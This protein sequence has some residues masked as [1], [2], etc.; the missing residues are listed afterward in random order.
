MTKKPRKNAGNELTQAEIA[1]LLGISTRRIR[2][3]TKQGILSP[4][5]VGRTVRYPWPKSREDYDAYRDRL[6]AERYSKSAFQ[7]ER[8]LLVR[9]QRK[10]AELKYNK[11]LGSQIDVD[12]ADKELERILGLLRGKMLN[13]RGR[14]GPLMVGRMTVHAAVETLDLQM[15]E[16]MEEME[17]NA[18]ELEGKGDGLRKPPTRGKGAKKARRTTRKKDTGAASKT[19]RKRVG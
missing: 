15:R 3:L 19:K 13:F 12:V 10:L 7:E 6:S 8:T 5:R 2:E 14:V 18:E 9:V 11:K 17:A 16:L 1:E 4:R